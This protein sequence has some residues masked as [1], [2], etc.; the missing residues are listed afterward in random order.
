M[1]K[2]LLGVDNGGTMSKAALYDTDGRELASVSEA[3]RLLTPKPGYTERDMEEFWQVTA[4]VIRRAVQ[5]AG[6]SPE[7]ILGV[8]CTGHG[9]GLYLWGRDGRPAAN[10]IIST[11][12]RAHAYISRW[13]EDGTAKRAGQK[14]FQQVLV[15]QPCALLAWMK[16]HRPEVYRNIQW[17]FEAK[18]Y[19]RFRLTGCARGE[20]T[21]YSGTSLVNLKTRA[22]DPELFALFGISEMAECF[23]PLCVS[24]DLCGHVTKEA[25]AATG[26]LE[27]TPVAGGMFDI[28]ACALAAGVVDERDLCVIAG[29]WGINEYLSRKPVKDGSVSM[30][31]IFAIPDYYLIEESSPT[32][33][34][35][36]EWFIH[37]VLN[38]D[39]ELAKK[40]GRTLYEEL[41]QMVESTEPEDSEVVYLPFLFG[42]PFNP[43]AKGC[44]LGMTSF[45]QKSQIVRAIY[46]GVVFCHYYHIERL[47][48]SRRPPECIRLAG[49][50]A[51]SRVWVQMFADVCG[52]PVQTVPVRELGTLGCAMNVAVMCGI[53]GDYREAA[54]HMVPAGARI[55]P[56][57]G[58]HG[59]YMK[60]YQTYR[61]Y[62]EKLNE[63]WA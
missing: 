27:G 36:L 28:D 56:D 2:Y 38:R 6:I 14:T 30:N 4:G 51:N 9:K 11:D 59:I 21:D 40:E 57:S 31:S 53:Y 23:P 48:S 17:V 47:L 12:T 22:Y 8:S 63:I 41:N 29:T 60:K 45:D 62:A 42:A 37:A 5:K 55:E 46:E 50:A 19:I 54:R 15:S 32:S 58:R 24:N 39:R 16:E 10:G 33:A 61:S 13:E 52:L 34:G 18:D 44:L 1:K 20:M 43:Q 25:A 7:E 49:G 35:N 26:L 3:T